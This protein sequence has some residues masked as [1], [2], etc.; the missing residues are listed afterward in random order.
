MN[1]L[2]QLHARGV[3][4]DWERV[5]AG[6]GARRVALPTYAF[7]RQRFWLNSNVPAGDPAFAVEHPLLDS[8]ISVPDTGGV[9]G[10][11]RLS[12]AAQPWLADHAVSGTVLLPGAALVELA[13]RT[14]DEAD[15]G[16]LRELVIEA[17]LVIPDE[18]AV[19]V[20]VSVGEDTGSRVRPVAVYS[21]PDDAEPGSP[22]VR[23]ASGQLS[24]QPPAP[25]TKFGVWPPKDA[26]AV[27]VTDLYEE[28]S[29]RGY[30]YGPVFQGLR[31]VWRRDDEVFAE[32]ALPAG[33]ADSAAGFGLHPALL[34]AALHAGA[35][36]ESHGSDGEGGGVRLPFAWSGV[37]LHAS[38]ASSLRVRLR[39]TGAESLS[40]DL[41]D[42]EGVPVASVESLVLRAAAE[43][44]LRAAGGGGGDALFRVEWSS[45]PVGE[46]AEAAVGVE[47]LEVPSAVLDAGAVREVTAG[48]LS[49]VQ[50][51][52]TSSESE[53][54]S[55][56]LVVVTRGAVD[57][58]VGVGGG[59]GG[60]DPVAAAVWGLV[61]SA[62]AEEP[63]RVVLVDVGVGES[64]P[65]GGVLGGVR[66]SGEP[67]VAVRSGEVFVPRL[68]R[69]VVPS[70]GG[71]VFRSG[72]TVLVT[73]GTG[74]LGAVVARHL[75]VVHGVRSLVLTS[76]SGVGAAGAVAL[77]AELEGLGARVVVAACDVADREALAGLLR[78]V[79]GVGGVGCAGG[80]GGV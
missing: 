70:S 6:T 27:D 63:G 77:K 25:A 23:H 24:A 34:D 49:A 60:V 28:L 79:G 66:A 4:V 29:D 62:Q 65:V 3:E 40:L 61:R 41:A 39:S 35:F 5:F 72:G 10:T 36:A 22:W 80:R 19:R 50:S 74:T 1:S 48:V 76:R 9:L 64:A 57:V 46:D 59:S 45:L 33:E 67:Q 26:T 12:L 56:C 8:V 30:G 75:V 51:F 52:L 15:T 43:E 78:E 32:V 73:G 68:A 14:G 21:R 58:G 47:V 17:P 11:G 20:Q 44:Q 16:T 31:A 71:R 37:S 54:G 53:S 13:V 55:G 69:A 7:Q 2:G 18:G 38:G 42:G